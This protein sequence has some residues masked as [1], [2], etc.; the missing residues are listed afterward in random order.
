MADVLRDIER[1]WAEELGP[2]RFA[3]LKTLLTRVWESP[4]PW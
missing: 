1:E 4:L 2:R 3:D